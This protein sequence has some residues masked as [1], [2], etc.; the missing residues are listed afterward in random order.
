V[1]NPKPPQPPNSLRVAFEGIYGPATWAV[2]HWFMCTPTDLASPANIHATVGELFGFFGT[3]LV[4]DGNVA[5]T[6]HLTKAK[7][8]YRPDSGD[9]LYRTVWI[10]DV[11]GAGSSDDNPAQVAFLYN[12]NTV[13]PRRGGKARSYIPGVPDAAQL[14]EA[15]LTT[16]V[17]NALTIQANAYLVDIAT[18]GDGPLDVDKMVEMSFRTGNDYRLAAV[19]YD[20]TDCSLNQVMGSQ[21]RR[22]DRLRA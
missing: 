18:A 3:R 6:L 5:S 11:A 17:V 7:A 15:R 12:W 13:D 20:I 14:D 2:V 10:G 21:R 19:T 4:D 22:I 8:V 1:A 16:S 9:V